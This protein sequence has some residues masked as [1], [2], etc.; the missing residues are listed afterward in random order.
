MRITILDPESTDPAWGETGESIVLSL[1]Q[2]EWDNLDRGHWSVRDILDARRQV[3][4]DEELRAQR[5]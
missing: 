5:G 2:D 3:V 4:L 1:T